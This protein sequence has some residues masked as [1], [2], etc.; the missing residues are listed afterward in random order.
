M[1]LTTLEAALCAFTILVLGIL[2]LYFLHQ[3]SDH[4]GAIAWAEIATV[5]GLIVGAIGT[6]IRGLRR[7]SG[8]DGS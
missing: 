7:P 3:A 4:E 5:I 6:I 2:G 1:R 8:T